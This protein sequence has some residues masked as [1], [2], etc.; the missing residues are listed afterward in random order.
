MQITLITHRKSAYSS[1]QMHLFLRFHPPRERIHHSL[2]LNWLTI[3]LIERAKER[4]QRA[5]EQRM[6]SF[7]WMKI[8]WDI[9]LMG[10]IGVM[11]QSDP[12][13]PSPRRIHV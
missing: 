12:V 4:K 8:R 1:P 13:H 10:N 9:H 11:T 2:T 6:M 3:L 5:N 7:S